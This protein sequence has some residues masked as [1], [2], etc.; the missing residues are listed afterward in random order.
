MAIAFTINYNPDLVQVP[1]MGFVPVP[2]WMGTHGSDL[3]A[4]RK[5]TGPGTMDIGITRIDH[6]NRNGL[7]TIGTVSF[8]TIDNLSGKVLL[9]DTLTMSFSNIRMISNDGTVL[10][11]DQQSSSYRISQEVDGIKTWEKVMSLHLYP[12]PTT[13]FIS[14][15]ASGLTDKGTWAL[16][17]LTGK[18]LQTGNIT[19]V[20]NIATG[21][22]NISGRAKGI[23]FFRITFSAGTITRKVILQ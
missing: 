21:T 7:G 10:P 18:T 12:N 13:G 23:Y 2:S 9:A 8:V 1:T 20:N 19:S 15:S 17:D 3:I 22:I 4:I 16:Q 6:G 14:Y 11:V 5:Q